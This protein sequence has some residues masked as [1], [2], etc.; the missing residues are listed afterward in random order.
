[1]LSRDAAVVGAA[2]LSGTGAAGGAGGPWMEWHGAGRCWDS[3]G[4]GLGGGG[5]DERE[6]ATRGGG[7]GEREVARR[8]RRRRP[9]GGGDEG[10]ATATSDLGTRLAS[11]DLGE[12]VPF[13]DNRGRDPGYHYS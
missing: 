2:S 13:L 6:V 7:N 10:E 8:G 4:G 5:D 11:G 1:M 12:P 3:A 9:E